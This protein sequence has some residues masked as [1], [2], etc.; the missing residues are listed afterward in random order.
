MLKGR[1]KQIVKRSRKA[2][3]RSK[4]KRKAPVRV[5][6]RFHQAIKRIDRMNSKRRNAV[7]AGSS[8]QFIRD[9]SNAMQK[10]P[11]QPQL[12][13]AR[14]KKKLQRHKRKLRQIVNSGTPIHVKRRL[15]TQKGGFIISSILVPLIA[16][17]IGA[18]GTVAG[19]AVGAAVMK[20]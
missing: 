11:K 9:F 15:L 1:R 2:F 12:V 16:A 5:N 19:S 20:K 6:K 7:I 10:I 13:A 3:A 18:A 17:A 8:N 14:H 4:G